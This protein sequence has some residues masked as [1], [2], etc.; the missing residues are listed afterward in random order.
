MG[1]RFIASALVI[2]AH[3]MAPLETEAQAPAAVRPPGAAPMGQMYGGGDGLSKNTAVTIL[4]RSQPV[5]VKSEYSWIAQQ[6]PGSKI[7]NQALT[8][9]DADHRRYDVIDIRTRDGR[10]LTLWFEISAMFE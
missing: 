10:H 9:W 6:Y 7:L 2:A 4:S 3:C 8:P 5:G 1:A